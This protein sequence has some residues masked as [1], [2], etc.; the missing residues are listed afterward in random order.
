MNELNADF[1]QLQ[2]SCST[3]GYLGRFIACAVVQCLW[4]WTCGTNKTWDWFHRWA[5]KNTINNVRLF[6]AI[7]QIR[8][9]KV[10]TRNK[11]YYF[12]EI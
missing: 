5:T 11:I 8:S 7:L 3:K 12:S 4:F 10:I 9:K 2:R 6:S 1:S